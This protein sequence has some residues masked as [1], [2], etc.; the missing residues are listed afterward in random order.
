MVLGLA[1]NSGSG[2]TTAARILEKLG[3]FH[4]DADRLAHEAM[5]PGTKEYGEILDRFG[6][7]VISSPD[8][9]I[10]RKELGK[11]VYNDPISKKALEAIVHPV[12]IERSLELSRD[13]EVPWTFAVWDA[14]LL[15][16]SGMH[17]LCDFLWIIRASWETK[18][19]R[20][21]ERDNI[22]QDSAILRLSSQTQDDELFALASQTLPMSR[23]YSLQNDEGNFEDKV[24]ELLEKC[25]GLF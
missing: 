4:V 14:A 22:S 8:G 25:L 10:D 7:A 3:G 15:V 18:L 5:A 6:P 17:D 2:K 1:G 9:P 16:E 23:I 21:Q 11:I 12:V 13:L 24:T 20:I 19:V